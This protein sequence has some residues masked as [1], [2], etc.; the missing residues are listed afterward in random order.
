MEGRDDD[1]CFL[2]EVVSLFF[3]AP[4]PLVDEGSRG[5]LEEDDDLLAAE[6]AAAAAG[7]EAE[8]FLEKKEN[9][10]FCP[11]ACVAAFVLAMILFVVC[12]KKCKKKLR[13]TNKR[14]GKCDNACCSIKRK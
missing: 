4:L 8:G 13:R 6:P 5:A 3:D 11:L 2:D 10:F 1:G 12:S 7:L 14:K 9:K